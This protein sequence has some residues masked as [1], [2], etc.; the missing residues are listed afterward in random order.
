MTWTRLIRFADDSGNETF[1]EPLIDSDTHLDQLLA[2]NAL[3]AVEYKGQSPVSALTKGTKVH[4]KTLL[5]ILNPSDV[6]IIRCIGLNYIKHSTSTPPT[7][8]SPF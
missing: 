3:Y 4:V 8:P 6:P 7:Q 2:S 1:G 5:N